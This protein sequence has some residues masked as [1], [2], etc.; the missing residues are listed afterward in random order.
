MKNTI[1]EI[2]IK[3]LSNKL[4]TNR[5]Q[6]TNS[7]EAYKVLIKNW[8]KNT[9][10]LYEEFKVMLL[11]N[12]NEILGIYTLS[13]GGISTTLVD[14]RLLFAIVLKSCA[15]G[16]ITG[17]NHPSGK[18]KPSQSDINIYKKIQEIA[19]FHDISYLDNFIVTL[20]GKF[21]FSDEGF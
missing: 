19:K 15:T 17:H 18:L 7:D 20:K 21:S 8:D 2:Q 11:N 6:I 3:Y 16:I 9:I 12:S 13:R 10:E 1:A 4:K 14:L 5:I